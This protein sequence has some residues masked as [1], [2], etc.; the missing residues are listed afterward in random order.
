MKKI[1]AKSGPLR[2]EI[3]VESDKSISHRAVIFAA[4]ARGES[5]VENFLAAADTLST[6]DCLRQLGIEI[7]ERGSALVIPGRGL[8][9][10]IAPRVILYCGNSGTTMRLMSGVLAAQ[11]FHSMLGGDDSLNRRPMKRVIEPL[12]M[13]GADISARNH[14]SFA[15]LDIRGR[16][17][18]GIK[19]EL[20]VA[21]AQIKS[22]L[23]LAGLYA[24]G[25]TVVVEP[26]KS[27]DHTERMLS[28]MG[29]NLQVNNYN[30]SIKS[31]QGLEPQKFIVPGDISSAAFFM[32]AAMV[33]PGSELKIKD[34]GV[35]PTRSGIIDILTS[36]GGKINIENQRI[37]GGEPI[38]DLVVSASDLKGIVVEGE[39]IPR[40]I[41]EIPVLAVAMAVAEG[42]SIV[43]GASELRVKET[44][45]ISAIC[46]EL[47]KMGIDIKETE[48]GFVINGQPDALIGSVVNSHEDHRIAMCLA[49]AALVARGETTVE[50]SEA[51]A[52]SFPGFWE[53]LDT[54]RR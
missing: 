23:L 26:E 5:V 13:M 34:V 14:G 45:R 36:M 48:D 17:L 28:S 18:K 7:R 22:A 53:L 24:D 49:V 12:T 20:P 40:L 27:R 51:V 19:Y 8:N 43:K 38:A 1:I 37:V 3:V 30:I 15:P 39:I 29:A 2:G 11:S 6:C 41:D 21:S 35:N 16:N 9:G 50:G 46:S 54:I 42:E 31:G 44:D 33:V 10:L 32:V 52:I 4:L 25:E 47:G